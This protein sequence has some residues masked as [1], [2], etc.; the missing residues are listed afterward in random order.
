MALV[1]VGI[2][3]AFAFLTIKIGSCMA[4]TVGP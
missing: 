1:L 3:E 4:G 2:G